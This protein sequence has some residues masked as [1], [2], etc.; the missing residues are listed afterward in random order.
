MRLEGSHC[1]YPAGRHRQRSD[2]HKNHLE[3]LFASAPK[4]K[5]HGQ[6]EQIAS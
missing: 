6:V 5:I 3:W 1:A 4:S 2:Y